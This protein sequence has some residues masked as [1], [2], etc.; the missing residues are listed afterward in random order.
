MTTLTRPLDLESL[1]P[2]VCQSVGSPVTKRIYARELRVFF[3][4][5]RTMNLD[6]F[7]RATVMAYREAMQLAPRGP[8]SINN[9]LCAIRKLANEAADNGYMDPG[10]AGRIDTVKQVERLG[11]RIGHWL[12]LEEMKRLLASPPPTTP[13]R[14]MRDRTAVWLMGVCGLRREEATDLQVSQFQERDGRPVLVDVLGKGNRIRSV[15]MHSLAAEAVGLWCA[16]A[17]ITEGYLLPTIANPDRITREKAAGARLYDA[18]VRYC[19]A[20]GLTFRPHDLRR[21]FALLA[22]EGGAP[23]REIADAL[24]HRSVT[25]TEI[26]LRAPKSMRVA[27]VDKI[28]L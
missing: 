25:T 5:Y 27:A 17:G 8:V 15:P 3:A 4:W 1:I 18:C 20:L 12:S 11:S 2:M 16:H 6:G 9:A 22:E 10:L 26:Y 23:L 21:S 13:N 24:G 7:T 14:G 19:A 28:A